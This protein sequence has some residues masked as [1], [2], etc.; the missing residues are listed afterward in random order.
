M[1]KADKFDVG[2]WLVENKLTRDSQLVENTIDGTLDKI[3]FNDSLVYY[4]NTNIGDI[5][6]TNKLID[7]LGLDKM[8]S[9]VGIKG[10]WEYDVW[11]HTQD[12]PEAKYR[13]TKYLD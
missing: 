13:I 12:K 6:V 10:R 4:V 11:D 3:D 2:K 1:K 5:Y 7:E 8:D 9:L